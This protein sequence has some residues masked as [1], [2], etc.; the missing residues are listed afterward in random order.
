MANNRRARRNFLKRLAWG[1]A[2]FPALL[3]S[4]PVPAPQP[5]PTA[6][7]ASAMAGTARR[8]MDRYVVP[9]LSVA[10]ARHGQLVYSEGFGLA[11]RSSG[12]RATPS[13]LFRI[14]SVSKPITAAAVYVLVERGR[15]RLDEPVF[16]PEGVLG[17]DYA[18]AYPPFTEEVT[19]RHLLTHT[20]GGWAMGRDDPMFLNPAMGHGELIA[21][22]LGRQPLPGRP[23]ARYAYSNF[24]YCVLGR[25][26]EKRTG[27]AYA[28]AVQRHVLAPCGIEGMRLAG[29]ALSERASGEAV[30]YGQAGE[31]PYG[32]NVRRMDAHGGWLATPGDLVRFALHVDGFDTVPDILGGDAIRTMAT[33]SSANPGYASGWNVNQAGNGWHVGSLPGTTALLV[34]TAS[35]LCWAALANTRSVGI[36]LALDGVM[37]EMA[38]TVPMW[39]A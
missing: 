9:G 5:E 34:R 22:T 6:S 38:S 35:G 1:A 31:D 21:W 37:W 36:D 13:H 29:N 30:Y 11:D 16:G 32:M 33:A 8:F 14:A 20:A 24:G 10:I 27:L 25:V 7:Q 15:L 26:L 28:E 12:E 39:R 17:F 19:V 3:R 18:R 4:A 2:A 23:G